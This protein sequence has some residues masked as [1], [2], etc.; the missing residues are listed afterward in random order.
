[1]PIQ[2]GMPLFD[3]V[4]FDCDWEDTGYRVDGRAKGRMRQPFATGRLPLS[5][6]ITARRGLGWPA[7]RRNFVLMLGSV[8]SSCTARDHAQRR[9]GRGHGQVAIR[10]MQLS[11]SGKLRRH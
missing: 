3:R 8:A 5:A 6:A 7:S 2:T 9:D 10:G 11:V 4:A 1:M